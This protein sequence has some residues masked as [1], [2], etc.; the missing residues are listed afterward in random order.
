MVEEV[1]GHSQLT[2]HKQ[3]LLSVTHRS[4][5]SRG[6]VRIWIGI[7]LRMESNGLDQESLPMSWLFLPVTCPTIELNE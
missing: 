4:P 7:E 3:R 5:I 1:T 6:R 2:S